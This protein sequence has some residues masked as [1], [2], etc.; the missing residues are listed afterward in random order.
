MKKTGF[1]LILLLFFAFSGF[2]QNIQLYVDGNE[3]D[4]NEKEMFRTIQEALEEAIR[5]KAVQGHW[6]DTTYIWL[7]GGDYTLTEPL[8]FDYRSSGLAGAPLVI[9]AEQGAEVN[10]RGGREVHADLFQPVRDKAIL[11]RMLPAARTKVVVA[12]LKQAG[13]TRF[14][15]IQSQGLSIEVK[16]VGMEL[17]YNDTLMQIARWPNT[18]YD[19]YG[20]VVDEGS[21]PRFRGMTLAPGAVPIDP[22]NPPE[23]FAK[24]IND[25]TN[26]PGSLLYIGDRPLRWTKANDLWLFGWWREPWASQTLKVKYLDTKKK[27]IG[28]EQPHHYGLADSGLYYAFNL[29]EEIDRPGEYYID[30][31]NGLL[32]FWPT[33]PIRQSKAIVSNTE[34]PLFYFNDASHV[35]LRNL[36][37]EISRGNAVEILGGH[38]NTI[39]HCI[40]RNIGLNGVEIKDGIAPAHHH[41]VNDCEFYFI[42]RFALVLGGGNRSELIPASNSATRNHFHDEAR[43]SIQGVG[44]QFRHNLSHDIDNNALVWRGNDHLIEYNEFFNCM[45]DADDMGVMYT[46][47]NPSGQGTLVRF[48]YLH[49]N[50]ARETLHT[51]SNGIYLDDG[52]TGQIIYGNVFYKTGKAARAKMGALFLHGAKDNLIVNNVFIDC[53]IAIGF[54]PWPQDRWEKFLVAGDMK[55]R[56]YEEVNIIDSLYAQRYPNLQRLQADASINQV[57]NNLSV[58]C[59]EFLS[60]PSARFVEQKTSNNWETSDHSFFRN[61]EKSDFNLEK[62]TEILNQIPGFYLI[63]FDSIGLEKN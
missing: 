20:K 59:E 3:G 27:E 51:G 44:N 49:H 23:R 8:A 38:H 37:I 48:N 34:K 58:N 19:T 50:G 13:I 9:S 52:T 17:V 39:E 54:S 45:A 55:K 61:Y 15:E 1:Q 29:L 10:I 63:P 22:L 12:D 56:L 60:F 32:Y 4:G 5:L 26:R 21:I 11:D 28:F 35:M 31:E 7:K 43:V 36:T 62:S 47:R 57:Y 14:D 46:G 30:R 24:Y 53:P 42:P 2:A 6:V 40:L 18:G 41:Q 16:P 25:T 33:S